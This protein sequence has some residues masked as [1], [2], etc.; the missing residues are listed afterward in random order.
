MPYP[1]AIQALLPH[2]PGKTN[3]VGLSGS[4]IHCWDDRVLKIEP[5]SEESRNEAT[6]MRWLQG[7]VPVPKVLATQE[8][9]GMHY[10]LMSRLNGAMFCTPAILEV[11]ER[12]T[13]LAAEALHCLWQT[14][15]TSCPSRRL[16]DDRLRLARAR[17]EQGLCD[18]ENAEP[19]TYG[20]GGFASPEKLLCWLENNRPKEEPVL[21]HGDCCL[22][23]LFASDNGFSGFIDLGRSGVGDKWQDIALLY[24]S[25]LHNYDG[26]YG[27]TARAAC[28][29][30]RLF[31]VLG[32]AR[33]EER[34]RYYIL[35][36]EL[37]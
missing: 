4:S 34:L 20:H 21:T 36:D 17:V 2:T 35:L 13:A 16:L 23:N 14:D 27:Y 33:D 31:D 22:P 30:R 29:A 32:I 12:L 7:R 28:P 10:L 11:P 25:T 15:I 1:A 19:G 5:I 8:E 6:M 18:T 9:N 26:Y 37:F 24:R 3:T